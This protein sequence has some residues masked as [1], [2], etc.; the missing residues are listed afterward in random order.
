[1]NRFQSLLSIKLRHY[2]EGLKV[3]GSKED[4]AKQLQAGRCRLT[5]GF[6]S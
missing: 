1:M 3:S 2:T 5:P 4:A 6:R